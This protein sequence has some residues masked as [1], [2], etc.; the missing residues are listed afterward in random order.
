MS[1]IQPQSIVFIQDKR[2]IWTHNAFY[3][4][5]PEGGSDGI[6]HVILS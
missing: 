4:E 1:E 6:K 2:L 3:G 5:V